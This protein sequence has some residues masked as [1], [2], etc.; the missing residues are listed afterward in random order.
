M[1]L[2]DEVSLKFDMCPRCG[3][4]ALEKLSTHSYCVNCNYEEVKFEASSY[5]PKW[6]TES[7]K[8]VKPKSLIRLVKPAQEEFEL[9]RVV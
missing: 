8:T 5:I 2:S 3:T 4:H 7:F 9:E 1:M 6:A